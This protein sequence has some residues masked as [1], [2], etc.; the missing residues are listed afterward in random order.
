MNGII[1]YKGN[2]GITRQYAEWLSH[3]WDL[4][5]LLPE[6]LT[7][8]HLVGA[9][10]LLLVT[11]L[12]GRFQLWNWIRNNE[13]KIRSKKILLFI[14]NTTKEEGESRNK[15]IIENVPESIRKNCKVY[16]LPTQLTLRKSVL[17]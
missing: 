17:V 7:K 1:I 9:S 12:C 11:T 4:V 2:Q 5:T 14:V 15:Y 3:D 16:F 10:F 8:F 13:A 6:Q